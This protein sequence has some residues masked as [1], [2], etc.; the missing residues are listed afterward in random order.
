MT[1]GRVPHHAAP[2]GTDAMTAAAPL[3]TQ[4]PGQRR[5]AAAEQRDTAADARDDAAQDRDAAADQRDE[6]ADLRDTESQWRDLAAARRDVAAERR[7]TEAARQEQAA[8]GQ[9]PA[10]PEG[11][12]ARQTAAM[13]RRDAAVD[14]QQ[15]SQDREAGAEARGSAGQDRSTSQEDRG[16][17]A[18]ERER[19]EGDRD[20]AL[21]DRGA[22]AQDR[23]DASLD[24]LTGAYVRGAGLLQLERDLLRTHRSDQPLT[25][26]F[27]DVDGLKAVNDAGGHAAGDRLLV[28]VATVLRERLRP[29]DL[30]VRYGGDEFLCVLAGLTAADAQE[31]LALVNA[32]L[33]GRGSVSV[34]V[35]TARPDESAAAVIARADGAMY[36][37]RRALRQL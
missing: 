4:D 9:G 22:S 1:R 7:D 20:T 34:G 16:S 27:V 28:R 12:A 29:Y 31:R 21:A 11:T 17:G 10:T 14:R 19:A 18:T 36:R 32:D 37:A 8:D 33:A 23:E 30:V 24:G 26:G 2:P 5:D 13:T 35:A 6:A 3:D 15:S 25:L